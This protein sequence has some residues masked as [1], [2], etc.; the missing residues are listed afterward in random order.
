MTNKEA[1][2]RLKVL[3]DYEY[4]EDLEALELAIQALESQPHFTDS[5]KRIFL[6]AMSREMKICK[7]VC[8]DG[9][10]VVYLPNVVASIESKVKRSEL[11]KEGDEG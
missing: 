1:I 10:H 11:W 8:K 3:T 7:E 5:E 4:D 6:S 2:E 9:D